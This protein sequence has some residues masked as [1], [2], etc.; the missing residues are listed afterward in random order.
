MSSCACAQTAKQSHKP[1][2]AALWFLS[3]KN[4]PAAE[5]PSSP[6]PP[7]P[8]QFLPCSTMPRIS[9]TS[10]LGLT[11]PRR[12]PSRHTD[13]SLSSAHTITYTILRNLMIDDIFSFPIYRRFNQHHSTHSNHSSFCYAYLHK[14]L[15][16]FYCYM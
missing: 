6:R 11:S 8:S 14:L 15:H 5:I 16:P 4:P 7:S 10:S 1:F 9:S 13:K 3:L 2:T 12:N